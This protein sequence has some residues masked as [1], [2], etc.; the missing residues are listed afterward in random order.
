MNYG[1]IVKRQRSDDKVRYENGKVMEGHDR[2]RNVHQ[3]TQDR[4]FT[5]RLRTGYSRRDSGPDIHQEIL[6]RR[7]TITKLLV[8]IDKQNKGSRAT[9]KGFVIV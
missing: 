4:I 6:T 7:F 5:N 2:G 1:G 8:E 3:K 9:G